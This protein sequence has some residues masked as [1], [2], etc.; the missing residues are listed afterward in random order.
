M[1]RALGKS[2][3][4]LHCIFSAKRVVKKVVINTVIPMK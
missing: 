3:P 2:H 1:L 4:V